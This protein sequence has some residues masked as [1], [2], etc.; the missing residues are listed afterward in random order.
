MPPNVS[1]AGDEIQSGIRDPVQTKSH[2]GATVTDRTLG[3]LGASTGAMYAVLVT[4]GNGLI[5]SG[6]RSN[7]TPDLTSSRADVGLWLATLQAPG[8]LDWLSVMVEGAGLLC[9]LVFTAYLYGRLR[10]AEDGRGWLAVATLGGGLLA[11]F[12]K[13][14]SLEPMLALLYRG[15]SGFDPQ[16]ATALVDMN[17]FGFIQTWGAEALFL[18]AAAAAGIRYGALPGWL[19]WSGAV[20]A[21]LLLAAVPLAFGPAGTAMLLFLLWMIVASVTLVVSGELH[22]QRSRNEPASAYA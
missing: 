20:V 7:A 14:G 22:Q 17:A 3:R 8:V 1:L 15:Q 4:A 6:G 12:I 9:M 16:V 5:G 13:I 10:Q 11:V 18:G 19:S 2:G 21:V